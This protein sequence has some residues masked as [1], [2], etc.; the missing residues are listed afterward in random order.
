[1]LGAAR[2][3]AFVPSRDLERAKAF[4]VETLA[5]KLVRQDSFALVLNG[6]GTMVRVA[7]NVLSLTEFSAGSH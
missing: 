3:I 4:Y 7:S 6:N 2:T 1:M 5:L